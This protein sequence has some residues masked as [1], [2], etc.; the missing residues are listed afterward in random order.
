MYPGVVR[1]AML[2]HAIE[3]GVFT[4][5]ESAAPHPTGVMLMPRDVGETTVWL[6]SEASSCMTGQAIAVDGGMTAG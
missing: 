6:F 4:E 1:T 5:T 3:A 2:D